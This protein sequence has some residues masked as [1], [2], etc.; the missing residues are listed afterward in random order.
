MTDLEIKFAA[1]K[2]VEQWAGRGY[3]KG[4]KDTFWLQLLRDILGADKPENYVEF[5][6]PVPADHTLFIDA[7]LKETRVIIEQKGKNVRLDDSVFAQAKKYNDAL[8]FGRRARW[9][10]TCNF[11]EFM[12]YDMDKSRPKTEPVKILLSELPKKFHAFDILINK[13]RNLQQEKALSIQASKIIGKLYNRLR[14]NYDEPDSE[15]TF[16]SLNKLCVRLVFCLYAESSNVFAEH[17]MF[18][19]YL[20]KF[21]D[22]S[23]ILRSALLELFDVLD[24]PRAKRSK[25]I[26]DE[27]KKFPHVDGGLFADKIDFPEFKS[28]ARGILFNEICA[29]NWSEI[30]PT[31]FGTVFQVTLN[32]D[33]EK[34]RRNIIREEGIQYTSPANIHKVINPLFMENLY[35]K[36]EA[37]HSRDD[38]FA[39]Q[40]ELASLK[41]FDPACGS[42]NFL[43]ESYIKIRELENDILEILVADGVKFTQNP[44]KVSI[45][46]FYG[47]EIN[48][49]AVRVAKTALWIS[50]IQMREKTAHIVGLNL[51]HFPI[52]S[53]PNIFKANAL[54]LDWREFLPHDL[55][56]IISNPPFIGTKGQTAAQKADLVAV[57][58]A[59]KPLDYV[60]GWYKKA[61]NFIFGTNIRAAFI[62]TNSI[63][64][65]EQ[66]A[67]LWKNFRAHID[68]AYQTFKWDSE[69]SSDSKAQ[70][71]VVIVGF[72]NLPCL[73]KKIF[74][75]TPIRDADGKILR[76]ENNYQRETIDFVPAQNINGYLMDAPNVY[77]EKRKEPLCSVPVMVMGSMIIDDGN[78]IIQ[79]NEYEKFIE[80]E[81]AAK[82]YIHRYMSSDDFINGKTRYCLWLVDC[83]PNELFKM[84]HVMKRVNAVKIFRSNS[85][86]PG[87]IKAA[88]T[89]SLFA[90][91]RQP[92]TN[93]LA[94]PRVSSEFRKYIPIGFMTPDIIAS[95]A[96]HIV[97]NA[98]IYHFGVL[99]SSVHMAWMKA[100]CGRLEMRYRYSATI[101]YN[102]FPWCEPSAKQRAKIE[103]TAQKILD[104]RA[105]Y[106]E[107]TLADL[108]KPTGIEK[109][110]LAAHKENDRAV[111]AAYG[112]GAKMSEQEIVAALMKKY[113][114]LTKSR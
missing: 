102:N 82:K 57:D 17:K 98:T 91:I 21:K 111:M 10:I 69:I 85:K 19:D 22:N 44:V 7:Y 43:T 9:I 1:E 45:E 87:T 113:L 77:V 62:S 101:V 55:N 96:V 59:L 39:L 25:Y 110:L 90:E 38:L 15:E 35:A 56:F 52:Q 67:I 83:P 63:C 46:Q 5:E 28:E 32:P 41:F 50:E 72:S 78:L 100:V 4:E 18:T 2:F 106:P 81:P 47:V 107:S 34:K 6:Y 29:F 80:A 86:R 31:I 37:V 114:A 42:G 92:E 84:K 53:T 68:F 12:I 76:D 30:S 88:E 58:P 79:D 73:P 109:D 48:D 60:A 16:Q 23:Q 93:Y 54:L 20:D 70:V 65:G 8:N 49:F 27:L 75:V 13:R 33:D 108:Y 74:T 97:P 64:Q 26:S 14:K 40:D 66:V 104:A 94:I 11:Q 36:L 112:F 103:A 61:D 95:D 105:K 24:T 99:T 71:H 3:E 51:A 89:P